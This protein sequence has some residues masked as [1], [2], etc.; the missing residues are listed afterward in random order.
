[1]LNPADLP[2]WNP[3]WKTSGHANLIRISSTALKSND[4]ACQVEK[5]AKAHVGLYVEARDYAV[6]KDPRAVFLLG[7]IKE[8]LS[9]KREPADRIG[10]I[11]KSLGPNA[12]PPSVKAVSVMLENAIKATEDLTAQ[13]LELDLVLEPTSD[14]V[15]ANTSDEKRLELTSWGV[16]YESPDKSV[17][18]LRLLCYRDAQNVRD[19]AQ[20]IAAVNVL[21][22]GCPVDGPLGRWT[23]AYVTLPATPPNRI[24]V[25]QI[26]CLDSSAATLF[27]SDASSAAA[28][29][30]GVPSMINEFLSNPNYSPGSS[31]VECRCRISC[32]ACTKSPGFLGLP[33]TG[34]VS[35]SL[36]VGAL[37]AYR[38]CAYQ[39][40][41]TSVLKLPVQIKETAGALLRGK[42]IHDWLASA[43]ERNQACSLDDLPPGELGS[44]AEQLGWTSDQLATARTWLMSHISIC[45]LSVPETKLQ[46]EQTRIAWDSDA[47]VMITT[48]ADALGFRASQPLWRETKSTG[49]LEELMAN[50][51][52]VLYPQIAFAICLQESVGGSVELE[53]LTP[54]SGRVVKFDAT[55]PK[56][57]LEARKAIATSFDS[58]HHDQ[59]FKSNPG[60]ACTD[61]PVSQ[62]CD[63]KVTTNPTEMVLEDGSRVNI[64]TGEIIA[65]ENISVDTLSKALALLEPT[66][67]ID[68]LPF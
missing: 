57:V 38:R 44:I 3:D 1:M 49:N 26:G 48:R 5:V 54:E 8:F 47:D 35:K 24:R 52:L 25:R 32:P 62:W 46:S 19:R 42:L 23:D 29:V 28:F 2:Q 50:E 43:H 10:L 65:I 67:N 36:S 13:D 30:G 12:Q 17:R 15:V 6:R 60:A 61:C 39:Y 33:T 27:D 20:L 16:F 63:Q 53:L 37:F 14:F 21:L 55:D 68:D 22:N 66:E 59:S 41:L 51:Y 40:Y 56:V 58:L 31:C 34:H 9:L 4:Q 64:A 7:P 18:E 11:E 45:P